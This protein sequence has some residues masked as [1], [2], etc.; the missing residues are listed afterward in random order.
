MG[1]GVGFGGVALCQVVALSRVDCICLWTF[2][3]GD[4]KRGD[5]VRAVQHLA[6][7]QPLHSTPLLSKPSRILALFCACRYRIQGDGASS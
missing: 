1:A 3:E 7:N 6:E 2:P 5:V 4:S